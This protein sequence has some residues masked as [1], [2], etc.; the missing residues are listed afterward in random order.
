MLQ[1][2]IP[3]TTSEETARIFGSYD[4]NAKQIEKAFGVTLHNRATDT[5]DSIL[6][7]GDDAGV[8]KAA[9]A[10]DYLKKMAAYSELSEQSVG[11]VIDMIADGRAG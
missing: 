5:G 2:T 10:V 4:A 8:C 7:S 9:E 6:I 11:Y 3:T 1:R